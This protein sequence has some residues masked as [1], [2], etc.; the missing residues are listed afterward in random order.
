[1]ARLWLA[2]RLTM[3]Q[4]QNESK[5]LLTT[6]TGDLVLVAVSQ[7]PRL[8]AI[9]LDSSCQLCASESESVSC[10][11]IADCIGTKKSKHVN[12]QICIL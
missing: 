11:L 5:S 4:I 2:A 9:R 10:S 12:A 6:V 7:V 1:M 8:F 3:Q